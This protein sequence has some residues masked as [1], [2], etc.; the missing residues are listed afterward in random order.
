[1]PFDPAL[2]ASLFDDQHQ[3]GGSPSVD[4]LPNPIGPQLPP[5]LPRPVSTS[6]MAPQGKPGWADIIAPLIASIGATV[7]GGQAGGAGFQA[8]FS[9]G[10]AQRQAMDAHNQ[11]LALQRQQKDEDQA[12]R[13]D[14]LQRQTLDDLRKA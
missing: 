3:H 10:L 9:S 4:L 14:Q 1:M 6:G 11:Q 8:G 7:A 12:A 5:S 2:F 13:K